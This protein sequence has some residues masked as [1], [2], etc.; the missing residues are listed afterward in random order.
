LY[1]T[2]TTHPLEQSHETSSRHHKYNQKRQKNIPDLIPGENNERLPL[3]MK[4]P[5]AKKKL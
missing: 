3:E 2:C 4:M 1:N 5:N